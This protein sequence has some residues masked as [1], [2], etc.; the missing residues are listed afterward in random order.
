[1]Y[2]FRVDDACV[3]RLAAS[4]YL[5]ASSEEATPGGN[6]MTLECSSCKKV[7]PFL[8]FAMELGVEISGGAERAEGDA[9]EAVAFDS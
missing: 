3:R 6:F 4:S 7:S 9:V 1:M 2:F 5:L 8:G